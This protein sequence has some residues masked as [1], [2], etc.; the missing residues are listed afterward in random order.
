M[1][2]SDRQWLFALYGGSYAY[3]EP[4]VLAMIFKVKRVDRIVKSLQTLKA[5]GLADQRGDCYRISDS[6]RLEV[7]RLK[8]APK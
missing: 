5:Q 4:M 7:E 3:W 1:T 6:G 2:A 8:A